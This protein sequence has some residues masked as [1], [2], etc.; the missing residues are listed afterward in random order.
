LSLQSKDD[1]ILFGN[2]RIADRKKL[3]ERLKFDEMGEYLISKPNP[4]QIYGSY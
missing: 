3:K 2:D 4:L 1:G